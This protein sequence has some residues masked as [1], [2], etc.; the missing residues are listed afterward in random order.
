MPTNR[1]RRRRPRLETQTP[2]WAQRLLAGERPE[3]DSEGDIGFFWWSLGGDD[4]PG[5]PAAESAAGRRLLA[6][7]AQRNADK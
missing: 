3:R 5:L 2:E 1:T 4:V 7:L 6:R